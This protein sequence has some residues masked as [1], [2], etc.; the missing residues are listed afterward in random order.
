MDTFVDCRTAAVSLLSVLSRFLC[1]LLLQAEHRLKCARRRLRPPAS[2]GGEGYWPTGSTLLTTSTPCTLHAISSRAQHLLP[3]TRTSSCRASMNH[4]IGEPAEAARRRLRPSA[5]GGGEGYLEAVSNP[6]SAPAPIQHSSPPSMQDQCVMTPSDPLRP[7]P[8]GKEGWD[9]G[10][11][12][13]VGTTGQHARCPPPSS[14]TPSW[15]PRTPGARRQPPAPSHSRGM[16]FCRSRSSR[17]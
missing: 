7:R 14:P 13:M 1:C 10:V 16:H 15:P 6:P 12:S 8:A 9:T 11:G 4:A 17:T 5:S 3:L 2:G